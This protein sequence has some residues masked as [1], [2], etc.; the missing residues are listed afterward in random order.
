MSDSL[1]RY[2][3]F[4][5][6]ENPGGGACEALEETMRT[7]VEAEAMGFDDIWVAE[8]HYNRFAIGSA[9]GILLGYLAARTSRV[10]LGT[11]AAL[12]ALND[13]V[14]VAEEVA[15]LD[16]L[17][18]GRIEFGVARGGPFPAQYQHA[19]LASDE[20]ARAR[21]HE[22]LSMIRQLWSEPVARFEGRFYRCDGLSIE[23]RPL[24]R[25]VPVWLASLSAD[26]RRLAAEHG[27]GLMAT[28]SADLAKVAAL[29][30]PERAARGDFPFA[31]ARF[32]H[33]E[34]DHRRAVEHGLA[35]ARSYPG[36]M[37][38]RFSSPAN[39]PP[40][41]APNASDAVIL[42]NA[43]IGDPAHCAAQ[44]RLLREQL[45]PHRLLL[46][47]A[48]HDPARAR[49]SLAMFMREVAASGV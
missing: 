18:H 30:A 12:L 34:S 6:V 22:A 42:A 5:N 16:L 40:M 25:P 32:F 48:V 49:E 8:H 29:V 45:G 3:V 39:V 38:V 20:A 41:F 7:G 23:P 37:G 9:L 33:C 21:M 26:S 47:P 4:L 14:R 35:G 1:Q 13:P 43:V 28:P 44:L 19:G 46:K 24:Q 36:L 10:R 27:Y 15:T 31:I 11:G 2:G 17:S